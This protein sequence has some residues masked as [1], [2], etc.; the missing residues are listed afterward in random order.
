[1]ARRAYGQAASNCAAHAFTSCLIRRPPREA[2]SQSPPGTSQ[3]GNLCAFT[4]YIHKQGSPD[5]RKRVTTCWSSVHLTCVSGDACGQIHVGQAFQVSGVDRQ[6]L[7]YSQSVSHSEGSS[8]ASPQVQRPMYYRADKLDTV[9]YAVAS[10]QCAH[11][12]LV[13]VQHRQAPPSIYGPGPTPH[14]FRQLHAW[15]PPTCPNNRESATQRHN[16]QRN[17]KH[18]T[19]AQP[20]AHTSTQ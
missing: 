9:R 17:Q 19:P 7:R 15:H 11:S 2:P 14:V 18:Q 1:M 20:L 16:R 3:L 5:Q 10:R 13:Q 6:P 4:M 8:P 12:S